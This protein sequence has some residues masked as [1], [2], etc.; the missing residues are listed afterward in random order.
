MQQAIYNTIHGIGIQAA[1]T[2]KTVAAGCRRSGLGRWVA[3]SWE[4]V[5]V[6][7]LM[8]A[9]AAYGLFALAGVA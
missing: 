6:L 8:A 2:N 9:S 5:G 4:L 7:A 3:Q 1:R